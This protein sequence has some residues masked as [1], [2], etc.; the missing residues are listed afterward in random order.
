MAVLL[1]PGSMGGVGGGKA[2]DVGAGFP[3][4]VVRLSIYGSD[5][6]TA[7]HY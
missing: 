6:L 5:D 3:N 1:L 2:H 4:L 7:D